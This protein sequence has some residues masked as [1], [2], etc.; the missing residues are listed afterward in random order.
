MSELHWT[1]AALLL[2]VAVLGDRGARPRRDTSPSWAEFAHPAQA[3]ES[4]P[5][6]AADGLVSRPVVTGGARPGSF[7]IPGAG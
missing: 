1:G 7:K 4:E 6:P 3:Q 2:A 5:R